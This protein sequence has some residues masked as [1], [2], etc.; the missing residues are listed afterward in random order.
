MTE[1]LYFQ[2][3]IQFRVP[4]DGGKPEVLKRFTSPFKG[5]QNLTKKATPKP[6]KPEPRM[7]KLEE[8]EYG[9]L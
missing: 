3:V 5:S 2:T 6:K 1:F 4:T 8:V 7:L 9:E